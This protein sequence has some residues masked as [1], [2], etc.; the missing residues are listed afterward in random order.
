MFFVIAQLK[1]F[2]KNLK[3]IDIDSVAIAKEKSMDSQ[4]VK[5]ILIKKLIQKHQEIIR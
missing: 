1:I 5:T 3:R 4:H 2:H